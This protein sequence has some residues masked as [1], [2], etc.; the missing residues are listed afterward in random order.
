MLSYTPAH[1]RTHIVR[2]SHSSEDVQCRLPYVSPHRATAVLNRLT[3]FAGPEIP[4]GL[5][6]V[7]PLLRAAFSPIALRE[8]DFEG[9][10]CLF[11]ID[12]CM[13]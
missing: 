2:T 6:N 5:V 4:L 12:K 13:I 8:D 10:F 9:S 1:R 7:L 11:E 3:V